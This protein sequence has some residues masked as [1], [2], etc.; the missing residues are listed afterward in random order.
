M[1]MVFTV[2]EGGQ[3]AHPSGF[4]TSQ[5]RRLDGLFLRAASEK[6][7]GY[8]TVDANFDE[9]YACYT[10]F[11]REGDAPY[12]QF[13]I[14]QVGPQTM[15]YEVYKQGKGRIAKSGVFDKAFERLEQEVEAI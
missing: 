14:K 7:L 6:R 1:G 10:Y 15:M 4:T 11:M 13:F 5:F 3:N 2:I 8:R 9:K 12:L